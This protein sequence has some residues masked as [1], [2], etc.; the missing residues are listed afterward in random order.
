[1]LAFGVGTMPAMIATGVSASKLAGFM[2]R[3]RL[4][5][6]L[7]IIILG[8]ATL[9]MPVAKI[10]GMQDHSQHAGH[11]MDYSRVLFVGGLNL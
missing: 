2:S 4:G 5:A 10:T 8:L 11:T 7:L 6:G 3:R 9:A 1:M